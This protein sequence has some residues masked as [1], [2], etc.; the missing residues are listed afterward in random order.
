[1]AQNRE[2]WLSRNIALHSHQTAQEERLN[3]ISHYIGALLVLPYLLFVAIYRRDST[4]QGALLVHG[5]TLVLLYL[6]SAIY[7][8]LP[9][10][11]AKRLLRLCDHSAIYLLIAGTYTPVLA[12]TEHRAL[13]LALIWALALIG[14]LFSLIFW[15]RFKVFHVLTYLAMGWFIVP[16]WNLVVPALPP[17]LLKYVI[18]AGV[19]YTLG[20][21]LYAAKSLSFAHLWWHIACI[22][23]GL[24]FSTGF[25]LHLS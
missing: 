23:A 15:G 2:T 18:S 5:C 9:F 19:T 22:I 8:Q 17:A 11:D 12:M 13:L 24:L 1:M 16:I 4:I 21:I 20:V 3:S 10:G 14:I 25:A 6:S 7:H